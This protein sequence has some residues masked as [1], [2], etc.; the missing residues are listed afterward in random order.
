[1]VTECRQTLSGNYLENDS[2][3]VGEVEQ[4][5]NVCLHFSLYEHDTTCTIQNSL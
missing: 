1:M 4:Q 3:R 5:F 2:Q